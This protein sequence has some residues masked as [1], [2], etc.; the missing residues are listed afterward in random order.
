MERV[1][2]VDGYRTPYI[3]A[4]TDFKKVSAVELGRVALREL[5]ERTAIDPVEID[6]VIIAI[7]SADDKTKEDIEAIC[8]ESGVQYHQVN[9]IYL[10]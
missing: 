2:I 10:R 9:G 4:G 8:R 3:K 5:V 6:E 7:P 1:A